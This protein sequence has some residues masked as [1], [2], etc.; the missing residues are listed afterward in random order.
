MKN[1]ALGFAVLAVFIIVYGLSCKKAKVDFAHASMK[2][3]FDTYCA[4]CH[5]AGK[6]D[7]GKWLYDASDF[8]GS[9]KDNIAE[10]YKLVYVNKSMPPSGITQAELAK[11]NDWYNAGY[12]A[13]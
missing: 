3:W 11:F 2:P 4:S 6:S 7:A 13:K 8:N 9:I 10:I 5:A 12:S 1:S